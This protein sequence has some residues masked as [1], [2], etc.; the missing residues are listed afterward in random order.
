[1]LKCRQLPLPHFLYHI[2]HSPIRHDIRLYRRDALASSYIVEQLLRRSLVAHDGDD[3]AFGAQSGVDSR[4][5]DVACGPDDQ[6]GLHLVCGG[7][8]DG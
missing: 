7:G 3:V 6:D 2:P 4:G 1:M 5:A 8:D